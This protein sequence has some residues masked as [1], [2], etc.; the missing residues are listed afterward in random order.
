[1]ARV[2]INIANGYMPDLS[3]EEVTEKGGLVRATNVLPISGAYYPL[4]DK[5]TY[6]DTAASGTPL[7]GI[8][9][10]ATDGNNYN[11]L[12]TTTK[13][14]RF[15]ASAMSD[16]T[17]SV[18]GA[19]GATFW[20]FALY[21]NWLIATDYTDVPQIK[22]VISDGTNFTALGG[23][24]PN[25]KYCLMDHGHLIFAYLNYGSTTYPKQIM[26][27][28]KELP[29]AI[30]TASPTNLATGADYQ[31][32]PEMDGAITGLAKVGNG[33][34]IFA[35]KSITSASYIGGGYTFTFQRNAIKNIGCF[36]PGSLFSIGD[37]AFFWSR[38][39]VWELSAA[40]L[41]EIGQSVKRTVMQSL[42][43]AQAG[44]IVAWPDMTNSIIH[45]LY[46]STSSTNPDK[47]FSYNWAEGR[48]ATA[49][50]T[51][52]TGLQG[53]TGG[54]VIDSM[55]LANGYPVIDSMNNLID[56]YNAGNNFQTIV[57][58]SAD[59]KA[60]TLTGSQ[61]TAEFE[62]GEVQDATAFTM[63][64]KAYLPVE[65]LTGNS[66][67]TPKHR[68]SLIDVQTS[69]NTSLIKSDGTADI[70]VTNRRHALNF[71]VQ[72]FTKIGQKVYL[73]VE[74]SGGR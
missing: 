5:T 51:A 38:D 27:S 14:Y 37:K 47:L 9:V 64:K 57:I 1:M 22:K 8:C 16:F 39:S 59:S 66:V 13:L 29:E 15:D 19:Y 23:T 46:V 4:R 11:F 56:T 32:F 28:G 40:G 72:N 12:G 54:V 43:L 65:G 48:A 34:A 62:T 42:N 35:E 33:W 3:T 58:D 24:P 74:K 6:N 7:R 70:R 25:A 53:V 30:N 10:Q 26:W 61:L 31:E 17:R 69:G 73:D 21:G 63:V 68:K 44:K 36:Y 49:N 18:G 55:T 2:T 20:D 71:T 50:M 41:K 52:F 67:V 45:W 60:K